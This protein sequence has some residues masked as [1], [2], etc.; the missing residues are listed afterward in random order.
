MGASLSGNTTDTSFPYRLTAADMP[1]LYRAGLTQLHPVIP[2]G[3]TLSAGS[4]IKPELLGKIPG[5]RGQDG[6]W[7]GFDWASF[8]TT[9]HDASRW[10]TWGSGVGLRAGRDGY[11]AV[12]IDVTD[13][14]LADVAR[15]A[16]EESLGKTAVR[17]GRA[18]KLLML[19][20]MADPACV[21]TGRRVSVIV[22]GKR[23]LVEVLG[24]GQQF[25][26]GGVHPATGKQY[27]WDRDITAAG[28]IGV[29]ADPFD[30]DVA[31]QWALDGMAAF[32]AEPGVI[33]TSGS[34]VTGRDRGRDQDEL[35]ADADGMD[36]LEA[37]LSL[38]PNEYDDRDSYVRIG[39]AIKAAFADDP[40]RGLSVYQ[41]WASRWTGGDN[42]PATVESD[43]RRMKPPYSVGVGYLMDLL[44]DAGMDTGAGSE[45]DEVAGTGSGEGG[46]DGGGTPAS[47]GAE[48]VNAQGKRMSGGPTRRGNGAVGSAGAAAGEG[49]GAGTNLFRDYVYVESLE[50][51]ADLRT[52]ALLNKSQFKDRHADVGDPTTRDNAATRYLADMTQ[53][54]V[55]S[56]PTYRPGAGVIVDEQGDP[57]VNLWVPGPYFGADIGDGGVGGWGDRVAVTDDDIRPYLDLAEHVIPDP[58]ERR[59]V[60]DW[61]AHQ[62]QSPGVKCNW[63]LVLGSGMHGIGKDTLLEPVVRGLGQRNCPVISAADIQSQWTDWLAN[64]QLVRVEEMN[65]FGRREVM[66]RIK[67]MLASPPD[68]LRINSKGLQQYRVPNLVN[69]VFYTNHRD[70]ISI[71]DGDRRFFVVWSDAQPW[72]SDRFTALYAWLQNGGAARVC[73]WLGARDLSAFDARGRAEDTASKREMAALTRPVVEAALLE[74]IESHA[75]EFAADLVTSAGAMAAVRRVVPNASPNAIGAALGKAGAYLGRVRVGDHGERER[76]WAIRRADTWAFEIESGKETV[77]SAYRAATERS[78]RDR[79]ALSAGV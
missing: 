27:A 55:V 28:E 72:E 39:C 15:L 73:R 77:A 53:R 21:V 14:L 8:R 60:L 1:A 45:F 75:D 23:H 52:K 31:I 36:T 9:E 24:A 47:A 71:E 42:D 12:D 59:L 65:T 33:G 4:A 18:P 66:D 30:V 44:R 37:G 58:R 79:L 26:V 54:R 22:D 2:P 5:I 6:R 29:V 56:A 7:Y 69:L 20:R 25:V 35:H 43:W 62:L 32:G 76:V 78:A 67:P 38:L 50:R 3:A 34:G 10:S 57:R 11:F 48:P 63:H 16:I 17:I 68:E 40:A 74:L 70:A 64:G 61:L 49:D 41:E 13:P 51:F 19:Y 46:R